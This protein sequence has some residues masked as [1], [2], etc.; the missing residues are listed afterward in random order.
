[1][2]GHISIFP[3]DNGDMTLIQTTCVGSSGALA[4]IHPK[5]RPA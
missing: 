4:S 3:V 5:A 1:M 2:T